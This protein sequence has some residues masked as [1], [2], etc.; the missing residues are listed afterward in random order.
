MYSLPGQPPVLDAGVVKV[1]APEI[2]IEEVESPGAA[3]TSSYHLHLTPESRSQSFHISQEISPLEAQLTTAKSQKS[4]IDVAKD[5]TPQEPSSEDDFSQERQSEHT[6]QIVEDATIAARFA[7]S[8]VQS[9]TPENVPEDSLNKEAGPTVSRSVSD[10]AHK[11]VTMS[12]ASS[13]V[14]L[15]IERL[16][17]T[18]VAPLTL[19]S[20]L[21]SKPERRSL[22]RI[23]QP[24]IPRGTQRDIDS[25]YPDDEILPVVDTAQVVRVARDPTDLPPAAR[26]LGKHEAL[27]EELEGYTTMVAAKAR[28]DATDDKLR[29]A[30][31]RKIVLQK[32]T[33]QITQLSINGLFIFCTWWWPRYYYVL[34]PFI[35]A[36]VALNVVMIFNLLILKLKQVFWPVTYTVPETPESFAYIIPCYN[37]TKEELLKSL[38]SLADQQ[39][40]EEHKRAVMIVV[41]GRVRGPKM[42]KT[43]AQY[44]LDDI[45]TH[46]TERRYLRGAYLA[47]DQQYMDVVIQK[48]VFRG[49]P[50]F[51]VVKQQNQGKRDGLIVARSFLYNF[52]IR[53]QKPSVIFNNKFFAEMAAWLIESGIEKVDHLIG[54][55]ADTEFDKNCVLNLL[56]ESR[57][58]KTV[59]VCGYVSVDWSQGRWNLWRLYQNTE[60][61][62]AQCLR[63]LHQSKVTKKVSCLPGCC[64]LLKVCEETCG[65]EVLIEKFGYC[66]TVKDGLLKHIRATASEDRNHVCHMLSARPESQTR[67]ALAAKSVT[68]VPHSWSV[69]LSQRR[70]WT[71]GATSN[72][73]LLTF[74]PGVNWFERIVAFVNV[75][76]WYFNPFIIASL[77]SFI[78]AC[79]SKFYE[80]R[81][82][83]KS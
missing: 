28:P 8:D 51:C 60:Y 4:S 26:S 22:D 31:R 17:V 18:P 30:G 45:L 63:R 44:L 21:E 39:G 74:A 37:E 20:P 3:S 56:K 12:R 52:N 66:P 6:S 73:L 35:T 16:E 19:P 13:S 43:T 33:M 32:H 15:E 38:N 10:S 5:T 54:M 61:T 71:L 23:E 75:I 24:E 46:K 76:T 11:R 48:G 81:E 72:D 57:H 83:G 9:S 59:G 67:Q 68:D 80:T 70:R 78:L 62:I 50:Y 42:E 34:L 79:T 27:L 41:D 7:D 64:Q 2:Q 25:Y 1:V 49:L 29:R 65:Q 82:Y 53:Q 40:I 36:T 69:F 14:G 55:D 77:A 47:W 58:P